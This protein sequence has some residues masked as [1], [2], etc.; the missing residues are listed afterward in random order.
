MT[1]RTARDAK[2]SPQPAFLPTIVGLVALASTVMPGAATAQDAA[3]GGRLFSELE[4]SSCHGERGQGDFGPALAGVG[5]TYERVA[6]QVRSPSTRRMP[7]FDVAKLPDEGLADIHAYLVSLAAPTIADEPTWRGTELI[8][9]PT[10]RMPER[11]ELELHF[12]HRFSESITDAGKEGLYGLDSFAFPAFML[13]FGAHDRLAPYA[14]RSANLATWEYGVKILVFSEKMIGAPIAMAANV[15]GTYLDADGIT[16]NS[17][18]TVE[19][20]VGARLGNRISLLAVPIYTTNP[21]EFN[22]AGSDDNSFALGLGGSIKLTSRYSLD[23]EWIG[24]LSGFERAGAVDQWQAG[25]GIKIGG[26]VFQLFV[27]NSVFTTPDFMAGGSI[28]T[29]LDVSS[30]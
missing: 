6:S 23:G 27:T 29:G 5:L 26:H 3:R 21:D 13:S 1:S 8:N 20:P 2:H 22:G 24:N 16:T 9:L 18:F 28:R 19:L 17:R 4:C 30:R 14:G 10:P 7:T 11:R 12:G 25:V 15:G